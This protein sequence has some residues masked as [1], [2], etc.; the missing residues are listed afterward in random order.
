METNSD[1]IDKVLREI[2][3]LKENKKEYWFDFNVSKTE[4]QELVK[5]FSGIYE[6]NLK[7]CRSCSGSKY[8]VTINL[9]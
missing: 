7:P 6:I 8:D 3:R 9:K 5:I 2:E 4:M 1:Y